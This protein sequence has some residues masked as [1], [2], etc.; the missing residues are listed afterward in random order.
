MGGSLLT[1]ALH[2]QTVTSLAS[3]QCKPPIYITAADFRLKLV[4]GAQLIALSHPMSGQIS[5]IKDE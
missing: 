5:V 3:E 2:H 1:L 4:E